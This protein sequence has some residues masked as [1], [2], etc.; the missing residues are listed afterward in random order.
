[1][2]NIILVQNIFH[3]VFLHIQEYVQN[4]NAFNI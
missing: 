3:Y 4:Q 2:L 1:M